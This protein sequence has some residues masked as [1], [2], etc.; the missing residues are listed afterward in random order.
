M[1]R[2]G[3][4]RRVDLYRRAKTLAIELGIRVPEYRYTSVDSLNS[5]IQQGNL[6]LHRQR[7][8]RVLLS[9][10]RETVR[11]NSIDLGNGIFKYYINNFNKA[12]YAI[13]SVIRAVDTVIQDSLSNHSMTQRSDVFVKL[14]L[15]KEIIDRSIQFYNSKV[16]NTFRIEDFDQFIRDYTSYANTTQGD[17]ESYSV[18]ID[19]IIIK[20][21][22][23]NAGGCKKD[24]RIQCKGDL[25]YQH[26][27]S[28][29]NNC[30]FSVVGDRLNISSKLIKK[31][32]MKELYN[33]IRS[34][35]SIQ[36]N[37]PIPIS[38]AL[39]IFSRYK[40]DKGD[41]IKILESE[42]GKYHYSDKGNMESKEVKLED[43][44]YSIFIGYKEPKQKKKC[45][46]CLQTILLRNFEAHK[47]NQSVV[48]FVSSK[49]MKKGRSLICDIRDEAMTTIKSVIHY[50]IETYRKD[51]TQEEDSHQTHE[52]YIVGY[53]LNDGQGYRTFEG[54]DC[55]DRFVDT[56]I[57]YTDKNKDKKYYVN[58]YNGANF[59]HYFIWK[60]LKSKDLKPDKFAIS[61][62]SLVMLEYKNF[63]CIDLC[64]HL[65]GTLSQ[66]L[67]SFGCSIAK[68]EFDH[69]LACRW[70]DMNETMR[71]QIREYLCADV[72][73]LKELYEK[74]NE[75]IF[76]K[77]KLNLSSYISTSS[78]TYTLWKQNINKKY[79]IQLPSLEQEEGFRQ[80]VRGGRTYLSK[81]RFISNEYADVMSGKKKF[82]DINDYV[83]DTDVVSLYPTAMAKY[84]YPIGECKKYDASKPNEKGVMGVYKI[85]YIT[86]KNCQHSI[87]GRR[88]N[89]AL[90]WDLKD[91]TDGAWYTSVDIEDMVSNGYSI[92]YLEGWYWNAK[93]YIFKDYIEELFKKKEESKKGSVE[94]SLAKLFMNALYGKTIQRPIYSKSE[95]IKSNAH[96]WKFRNENYIKEIHEVGKDIIVIGEPRFDDKM[97][98]CISKP[99]HLGAFILAYSRRIMVNYMK[100]ANPYFNSIDEQ[101]RVEND[102]YY[103]DTD[104]L[105]MNIKNAKLMTNFGGKKLGCIDDDLGGAKIIRGLWIAPK[106]Y[107]LEYINSKN[108]IHHHFRGK[109]L[110]PENLTV[111]VFEKMD[112]GGTHV[113][114]RKF[115]MKKINI[116]R[117]GKQQDIPQFSIVH[118]DSKNKNHKSRLTRTVNDNKWVGR[119]FIDDCNSIPFIDDPTL[120]I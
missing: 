13:Q 119:R 42:T 73:G 6:K 111:A 57:E 64:K 35:F 107:M 91:E 105:Q 101:K 27:Q 88:E 71:K 120:Q 70:E 52:P 21:I 67:K 5:F 94:Y 10:Q 76:D 8:S 78:L 16:F 22:R 24:D 36:P 77:Y 84:E 4:Q 50:D 49:I 29:D 56:L 66:N 1:S 103:T 93:S 109:G 108:E 81:K 34:E 96:Y 92:E 89:G 33:N 112:K 30:F 115:Q 116:K 62:G 26:K 113:D 38:K 102:F 54:D 25:Q 59:D 99:T 31:N 37:Q 97:E 83:V 118:Y 18:M 79:F 11:F 40:K 68:G 110:T 100:E 14:L 19:K 7:F 117:N 3:L 69:D 63:K 61:N 32:N 85:R 75:T 60:V 47:C 95:V 39:Q 55:M 86:N 9:I 20:I 90:K 51:I 45:L 28:R 46:K 65:Q 58:A 106:L 114:T 72:M 41:S 17:G 74:V 23:E 44:H 43:G 80:A 87:G 48:S 12:S 98:T 2:V 53:D 104:S 82:D 15:K